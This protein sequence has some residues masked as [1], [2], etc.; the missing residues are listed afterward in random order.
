MEF[1][2]KGHEGGSASGRSS[3]KPKPKRRVV[4][5]KTA[6]AVVVRKEQPMNGL[7]VLSTQAFA[8][9]EAC[10]RNPGKPTEA[11]QRGAMLLRNLYGKNR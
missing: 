10:M 11:N 7:L 5:K 6:S 3:K 8:R 1:K 9:F 4:K 2:A